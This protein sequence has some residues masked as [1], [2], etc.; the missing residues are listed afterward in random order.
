MYLLPPL[1]LALLTSVRY[2][3]VTRSVVCQPE[4]ELRFASS[5]GRCRIDGR[6][7]LIGVKANSII[8]VVEIKH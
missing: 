3:S 8:A 2:L 5:Y 6:I 7:I 4:G 1:A